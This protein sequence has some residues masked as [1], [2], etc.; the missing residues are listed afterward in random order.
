MKSSKSMKNKT[1][2]RKI[3]LHM[4]TLISDGTDSPSE[5]LAY[6]K[7]AGIDLFSVTDHDALEAAAVINKIRQEDDPLFISGVEFSCKD[8]LGKYHILGYGYDAEAAPMKTLV[9]KGHAMRLEKLRLRLEILKKDFGID[10]SEEDINGLYANNNPGKPHIAN[11]MLKYNYAGNK[12]E[13]FSKFLNK[14]KIPNVYVLPGEAID[15]ILE[16]GG[17]PILA[18]PF[19]G[20]GDEFIIGDEMED[21]LKRLIEMDIRGVEGYYSRFTPEMQA[22]ILSLAEK[23]GLYVTAGSD[24]HGGNKEIRIGQTNLEDAMQA[25]KGLRRFL[26]EVPLR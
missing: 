4:H 2:V 25:H 13:A 12:D 6:V 3:D 8:N 24:Y 18:H 16:S 9:A 14:A 10:F 7:D 15:A 19:Y 21:R 1:K 26:D 20:S 11:L 17:I 5:I 23:Y 22:E